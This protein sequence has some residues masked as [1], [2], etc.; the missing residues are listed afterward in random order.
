MSLRNLYVVLFAVVL[1]SQTGCHCGGCWP[2]G[3]NWC[4]SQCGEVFWNE[5]FSLPPDCCDPCSNCGAFQ[6]P[7]N[8]FLRR[9]VFAAREGAMGPYAD[10]G[11]GDH[12]PEAVEGRRAD[13]PPREELPAGDSTSDAGYYNEFGQRASFDGPVDSPDASR[14]LGRPPRSRVVA[15]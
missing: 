9:G 6:G 12:Y 4:G 7:N 14:K 10:D 11:Y 1:S 15:R 8:R 3:K 5:W 13:E 2:C